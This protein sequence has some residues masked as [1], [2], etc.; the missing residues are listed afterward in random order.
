MPYVGSEI[1][2]LSQKYVDMIKEYPNIFITNLMKNIKAP[3]RLKE[4]F[5]QDLYI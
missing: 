3:R 2:K 1:R 4:R 5:P